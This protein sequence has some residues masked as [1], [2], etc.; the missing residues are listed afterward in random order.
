LESG[1]KSINRKIKILSQ[2]FEHFSE[3][4]EINYRLAANYALAQNVDTAIF[5]LDKALKAEPSKL[6]IFRA[7]Y[8]DKNSLLDKIIDQHLCG[9]YNS[10]L[11]DL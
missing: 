6:E 4:A 8:S 2:A 5:H 1:K 11:K 3:S 10:G 7:I 9:S